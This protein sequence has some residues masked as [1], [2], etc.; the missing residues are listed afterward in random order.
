MF[1]DEALAIGMEECVSDVKKMVS[2]DLVI[3]FGGD[4]TII[5]AVREL[6]GV[7]AP[8]LG[9]NLGRLGFL[10]T[11]QPEQFDEMSKS[12]KP[13]NYK[14][15]YRRLIKWQIHSGDELIDSGEALN[16]ITIGRGGRQRLVLIDLLINEK[17]FL[18]YSADG[19]IIASPT[20]STA[21]S[22]SAGGPLVSPDC[23]AVVVTPICPHTI[24]NRSLVLG[25]DDEVAIKI[26]TKLNASVDGQV[27]VKKTFDT[28]RVKL[29][30]RKIGFV[31]TNG[32]NFYGSLR[33]KLKLSEPID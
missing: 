17:H 24:F 1:K 19:I 33:K 28:I 30:D 11:I 29:S 15:K 7:K 13:K 8:F 18:T 27:V 26:K 5:R 16:D 23:E 31:T 12:L 22:L 14:I 4:G 20:G 32:D 25:P 6:P 2:S 10:A 9:I 3:V 21:Y